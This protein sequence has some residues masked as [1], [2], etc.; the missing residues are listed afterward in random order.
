MAHEFRS[1]KAF[2]ATNKDLYPAMKAYATECRKEIMNPTMAF[3]THTRDDM[4][5]LI[6]KE[7]SM[8]LAQ[9]SGI[10]LPVQGTENY[11]DEVKR[12]SMN[13][14]V[15]FYANEIRDIMID[16]ILPDT[17][18]NSQLRYFADFRFAELGDSIK[19]DIENNSL[20]TVS[21]AGERKRHT[22]LQ[23]LFN[24]TVTMTGENH[25][26]TIGT[27][28]YEILIGF[29]SIAKD[30]MK[31]A[32][33]IETVMLFEAY[34]TFMDSMHGLTGALNPVNYTE[35]TLIKLA[36]TVTAYNQG[37]KAIILGTPVSLKS[38]LPSNA[39]YRY[40]LNDEY[41]RDGALKDFNGYDVLPLSQVADPYNPTPYS[42]KLTDGEIYVVS[43]GAQK[44]VTIGVFGGTYTNTDGVYDNANKLQMTSTEK[45]WSTLTATNAVAG[46][47]TNLG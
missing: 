11:K 25:Q 22:N 12:Y 2:A 26:I 20:F 37:K 1:V 10:P 31:A 21:K 38:V 9:R 45:H 34:D 7:F 3:S 16:M 13:P 47:I 23:K 46:I 8:V 40:L 32:R 43:P 29:A 24:T 14:M 44:L 19:I 6:N 28:L 15:K 33:S 41:V 35:P 4:E 27:D 5:K 18:L 39:N 30:V 42:L 17:L 36:E